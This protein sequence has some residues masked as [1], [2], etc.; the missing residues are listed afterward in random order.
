MVTQLKFSW[1]PQWRH[2][3]R[4]RRRISFVLPSWIHSFVGIEPWK[5]FYLSSKIPPP[6]QMASNPTH[7][8]LL[9]PFLFILQM[10]PWPW[11]STSQVPQE[12]SSPGAKGSLR[13]S[14]KKL[15]RFWKN[16]T[17]EINHISQLL[18]VSRRDFNFVQKTQ[19][20]DLFPGYTFVD[21]FF[22]D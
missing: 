4:L 1:K 13:K 19:N 6:F 17:T 14:T 10:I 11:L 5:V 3:T 2:K 22:V 15:T 20:S 16:C 21:D 9:K 7:I 18:A 12:W 8:F